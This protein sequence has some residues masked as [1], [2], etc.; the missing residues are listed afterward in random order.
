MKRW[1]FGKEFIIY[2]TFDNILFLVKQIA[3]FKSEF[4]KSMPL[5]QQ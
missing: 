4:T 5:M 2:D 1:L 3:K